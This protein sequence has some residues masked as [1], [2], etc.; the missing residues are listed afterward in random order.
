VLQ[1]TRPLIWFDLETTGVRAQIDRIVQIGVIKWLPDGTHKEW[2][3][4]VNPGCKI[5]K[6]AM[7][8]HHI[9]DEMVTNAP[10]F[11]NIAPMLAHGFRDCDLAGYN[12]RTFD[13]P[14]LDAEF[15][16]AGQTVDFSKAH[17]IDAFKIYMKA[18]PRN[19][20]G[21]IMDML[22]EGHEEAHSAL[23]DTRGT[24]RAFHA[25]LEKLPH[26]PRTP[27]ELHDYCFG[28]EGDLLCGG[29]FY[30]LNGEAHLNFGKHK[31]VKLKDVP[32]GWLMWAAENMNEAEVRDVC[33]KALKGEY[34]VK[35]AK[36]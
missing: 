26:L 35:E 30:F 33:A 31:G 4:L 22:G 8:A 6:E 10:P 1:L 7:D 3:S 18:K 11:R 23:P 16:R 12:I 2:E 28:N 21:F 14:F 27:Q 15:K 17:V 13:I 25:L 24:M 36:Q 32:K 19:L 34:P 5:P 9:T 20:A 29:R